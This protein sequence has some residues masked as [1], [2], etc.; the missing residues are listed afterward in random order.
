[1]SDHLDYICCSMLHIGAFAKGTQD[2]KA[3]EI[4]SLLV[5]FFGED[6]VKRC[7]DIICDRYKKG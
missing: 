7:T 5:P 3:S 1:M 2:M 4:R 6:T